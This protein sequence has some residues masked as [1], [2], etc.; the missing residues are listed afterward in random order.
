[1]GGGSVGSVPKRR[2]VV[3]AVRDRAFLLGPAG[4]WDGGWVVVAAT[5][6]TCHDLEIWP[7][8]LA[9]C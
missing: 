3:H 4:I 5:P 8:R 6:V 2:K 7:I 9:C 1:M